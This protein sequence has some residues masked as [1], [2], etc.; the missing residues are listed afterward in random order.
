MDRRSLRLYTLYL[1]YGS[2]VAMSQVITLRLPDGSAEAMRQIAQREK[3]SLND[4]GVRIV[5]EW[6][7]QNRF[8]HIEFRPFQGERHACVKDRLQVWQVI[9]VAR[10][11]GMAVGET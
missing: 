9:L 6:L 1:Q 2:E 5:E 8:A 7:R 11:Y 3:R 4:I 10:G